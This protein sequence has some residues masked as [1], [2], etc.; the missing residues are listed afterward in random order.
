MKKVLLV[1]LLSVGL[2]GVD[3]MPSSAKKDVAPAANGESPIVKR[4][5]VLETFP[6][7]LSAFN[8]VG[9]TGSGPFDFL[10][11][12]GLGRTTPIVPFGF[13]DPS[14]GE[15]EPALTFKGL[16]PDTEVKAGIDGA[17][18]V[19]QGQQEDEGACDKEIFIAPD[20]PVESDSWSLYFDHI[21]PDPALEA[22]I[23]N[24]PIRVTSDTVIGKV[25]RLDGY[26]SETR[27]IIEC[28][29]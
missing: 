6:I 29:G 25:G 18:Y 16:D 20:S 10:G 21:I 27:E 13:T 3:A 5:L 12:A 11:E 1:F 26:N 17:I 8:T 23:A 19:I 14:T 2:A 7:D 9:G 15:K 24:G 28:G 4:P 22:A